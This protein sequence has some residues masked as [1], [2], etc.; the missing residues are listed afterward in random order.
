MSE[1][2]PDSEMKM[3]FSYSG[4]AYKVENYIIQGVRINHDIYIGGDP[5][6]Y[7]QK[8]ILNLVPPGKKYFVSLKFYPAHDTNNFK[9]F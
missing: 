9:F 2:N 5:I 8:N 7:L 3:P 4:S 6:Y 1:V